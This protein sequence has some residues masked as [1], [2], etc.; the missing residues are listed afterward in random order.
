M[1]SSGSANNKRMIP[2]VRD[3]KNSDVKSTSPTFNKPL[4]INGSFLLV[5][6]ALGIKK[7]IINC[8]VK[9]YMKLQ[10]SYRLFLDVSNPLL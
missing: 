4:T 8:K 9:Y 2:S 6:C 1:D 3:T 5:K 10:I 7:S